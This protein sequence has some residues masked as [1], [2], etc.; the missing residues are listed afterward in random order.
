MSEQNRPKKTKQRP[1]WL[2]GGEDSGGTQETTAVD[3]GD[4]NPIS[5]GGGAN[6]ARE[7]TAAPV[8][9][10]ERPASRR[11]ASGEGSERGPEKGDSAKQNG[12]GSGNGT[13]GNGTGGY[14]N[15]G[16]QFLQ[17]I[18]YKSSGPGL[19]NRL[20]ASAAAVAAW[21]KN[22]KFL[23][24]CI[25]AGVVL[26]LV[27]APRFLGGGESSTS[28][29]QGGAGAV[30]NGDARGSG[31][32]EVED[33]GISF[34]GLEQGEDGAVTLEGAGLSWEGQINEGEDGQTLTLE[35]PTAAQ[36][37]Q[38][39]D[40]PAYSISSGIYAVAQEDGPVMH[41]DVHSLEPASGD[42]GAEAI[43]QGSIYVIEGEELVSSGFY[44]DERQGDSDEVIRTYMNP[45]GENY[46]VSYEAPPGTPVPLLVGWREPGGSGG[47]EG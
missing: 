21:T 47:G 7:D 45:G 20:S 44:I 34:S 23:A 22:N 14:D 43:D 41:V 37:E 2:T 11:T 27:L 3:T 31:G 18:G 10:K 4:R 28:T 5:E 1:T 9:S 16:E 12:R 19:G 35:G 15:L 30:Q 6:A 32:G 38:G 13:G 26:L 25:V 33:T 29:G 24:A 39:F 42:A 46:R 40:L 36:F 8:A 17:T